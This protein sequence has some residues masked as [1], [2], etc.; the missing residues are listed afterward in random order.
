MAICLQGPQPVYITAGI[1]QPS[2]LTAH[3]VAGIV[4]AA[5]ALH[6]YGR[7]SRIEAVENVNFVRDMYNVTMDTAGVLKHYRSLWRSDSF[8]DDKLW[9]VRAISPPGCVHICC[10]PCQLDTRPVYGGHFRLIRSARVSG[11]RWSLIRLQPV[12][13]T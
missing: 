1:E 8:Y 6:E 5:L 10:A 9:A 3:M 12:M 11:A 13:L 7:I 2:D 4:S